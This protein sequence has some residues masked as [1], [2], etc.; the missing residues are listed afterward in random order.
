MESP[1]PSRTT[2]A[3]QDFADLVDLLATRAAERGDQNAY[4]FLGDGTTETARLTYAELEHRA[5]ALAATLQGHGLAG[6]RALL[7]YPPGL[8]FITAFWG[9]VYAGVVA[10]PAYPP[11]A[12]DR[13]GR[14]RAL[15]ADAR[16]AVVLCSAQVGVR[17]EGWERQVP[18]L[19]TARF[20]VDG[21]AGSGLASA[22]AEPAWVRPRVDPDSLAFLQY[23]SGS[24]GIPRGVMITHRNLLHNETMI[25][26]AFAQSEGSVVVG[27]LP[28]YH[29]MGL[30]GCML[31]PVYAGARCI[32][33]PPLAFLQQPRRWLAAVS[34]YRATTSGGPDFAY[35]L[36]LQ[37]PPE[38]RAG[39]DLSCWQVA[40][41]GAEPVRAETLER[42]AEAFSPCGFRRE[43]FYPCYGL[44]E[45]TLFAT[46]GHTASPPT[47]L[48]LDPAS[49]RR[50]EVVP[51]QNGDSARLVS[52]GFPWLEQRLI[53]ADPATA[54]E[55]PPGRVGEIW[56]SGPSVAAGYWSKEEE[57]EQV[58][59]AT[60][61]NGE[62]AFLRT[63][64]LGFVADGHLFIT[65]RLKD[66]IIIH[67]RNYY[68]QDIELSAERSHPC[69]RSS[70]G[71]A[72]AVE[73]EGAER[74]VVVQEVERRRES[75]ASTAA[76][77]VRQAVVE[78]HEV[79]VHEVVL[80]RAGEVPRTSSGKI[81]RRAC[82]DA[83]LSA[84]LH[85]LAR[86]DPA[87]SGTAGPAPAGLDVD[88]LLASEPR[89]RLA[90]VEAFL[91]RAA[92]QAVPAAAS[93][94]P[95]VERLSA[96][97]LDSLAAVDLQHRVA[98]AT[99]VELALAELLEGPRFS[100][101]ALRMLRVLEQGPVPRAA[102]PFEEGADHP[103]SYGQHAL[104]FL[105][106]LAP[107]SGAYNI[108]VAA[109]AGPGLDAGA[110]RR[111]A[112]ALG[113]RHASLRT[114]FLTVAGEPRQRVRPS[115]DLDFVE[116]QVAGA[117]RE[118]AGRVADAGYRPFDLGSGSLLR[119]R[120]FHRPT[121]GAVLVLSIHHI[122]CD[123]W[124]LS[125]LLQELTSLYRQEIGGEPARLTPAPFSYLDYVHRQL[126]RLTPENIGAL[127]EYWRERFGAAPPGLDLPTDRPRPAVPSPSGGSC[128]AIFPT[129]LGAELGRLARSQDTT[130][131]T[132]L[133]AAFQALLHRH[134]G[135]DEVVVGSPSA[136]RSGPE[137]SRVVGYF[138][139]PLPLRAAFS[140]DPPFVDHL[141]RV[142]QEVLGGLAHQDLPFAVLSG[143]LQP[144]RDSLRRSLFQ[145][146][147]VMQQTPGGVPPALAAFALGEPAAR[148]DLCGVSLAPFSL[149]ERRARFDLTLSAATLDGELVGAFEYCREL[150]DPATVSRLAR[151][152]GILLAEIASGPDRRVSELSLLSPEESHQLLFELAV[153]EEDETPEPPTV[154]DLFREQARR[155]PQATAVVC[156]TAS[157]SYAELA[158]RSA[159]LARRLRR[160]GIGPE[161][162]VVLLAGRSPG[163]LVGILGILEAGAAYL[164]VDPSCPEERLRYLLEDARAS[165]VLAENPSALRLA[166]LGV[167]VLELDAEP[168]SPDE[169][170]DGVAASGENLA[171]VIYTSGSTGRPKGVAVEHRQLTSY[172]R[173]VIARLGLA[174]AASFATVSTHAADLG[175][176]M[177][178]GALATGACLHVLSE[179]RAADAEA[180]AE[181]CRRHAV[182]CLKIV[183]SH[184]AAVTATGPLDW[185]PRQLVLGG[186]ASTW[187]E[188]RQLERGAP[189][190]CVFNHYGPTETTVGALTYAATGQTPRRDAAP[191]PVGRPLPGRE[192][193]ILDDAWRP[194]PA[195]VPGELYLGGG[196]SRGYLGAPAATA[197]SFIPHPFSRWPGA[198]LYRS[199]DIGRF[200]PDG[201]I[202]FL[203]RRDHQIK[204]RGFRVE[205]GEITAVLEEHSQV[206]SALVCAWEAMGER[207]LVAYVV[208]A[209]TTL[210]ETS[211]LA[212]FLSARLPDFMVP[213]AFVI[214]PALPLT[215]NGKVDRNRLPA[216]TEIRSPGRSRPP[217]TPVEKLLSEIWAEVLGVGRCCADDDF[218]A[219]GGHSLLATRLVSRLRRSFGVDLPLRALFEAPTVASLASRIEQARGRGEARQAPPILRVPRAGEIPLSFPQNRLWV[220]EQLEPG[221]ATY[222][223]LY[224]A[225]VAG[226]LRASALAAALREIV[227]RHEALRTTF[228][229]V[230]GE[231]FQEVQEWRG[232]ELP[233]IDLL[234]LP[235]C[236]IESEAE[237]LMAEEGQRPFD[238]SGGP[239]LRCAVVRVRDAEHLLLL[240]LHHIV[241]D[242]WS[243]GVL[244]SEL[245]ALY[246]AAVEE[247]PSSLPEPQL[248][249]A[250]FSIWQREWLRG[251]ELEHL[252]AFWLQRLEGRLAP[253]E[254]PADRPRPA[255]RSGRGGIRTFRL[256]APLSAAV[257]GLARR[258]GATRF[259]V[260]LAAF[261]V[262]LQ[263]YC[264]QDDVRVGSPIASRNREEIE[265]LIGFFS[266]TLVLR[267][268]LSG[269]P[270][271]AD[272]LDQVRETTLAAYD[273]QDLPFEKLVEALGGE[274]GRGR[275]SPLQAVFVLQNAPMPDLEFAGLRLTPLEK[276]NG[277]AKF[278][279]VLTL[280]E[281]GGRLDGSLQFD[282]DLFDPTTAER[283]IEHLT[284]LLTDLAA[285][286][287]RRISTLALLP[288]YARHRLLLEG[289]DAHRPAAPLVVTELFARRAAQIPARP[290]VWSAG[291]GPDGERSELRLDYGALERAGNR[292]ARCLGRRGIGPGHRVGICLA[293]S[294]AMVVA[295]LATLKSGAA[296]VPLD[297]HHPRSRLAVAAADAGLS[298]W[299]SDRE[300]AGSVPSG[301]T[302]V[303]DL[304]TAWTSV[305]RFDDAP[306]PPPE[307][308]SPAYVIYTSG[309]T[310][311]PK[312]VVISHRSLSLYTL[313][314]ADAYLAE[315]GLAVALY[316]SLAF[317]LTVTSVF[318]P[319]VA[320]HGICVYRGDRGP[321]IE[322]V[323]RD[324]QV[325]V[326]KLTPS[327]L[328]LL[329]DQPQGGSRIR[330]LVVGGEALDWSLAAAIHESF[331]GRV[332]IFN[333]YGPTEA[334]VGCM[335]HRFE[336]RGSR[337]A[338]VPIGRPAG[339][340]AVYVLD[341]RLEPVPENV[342]GEI[343]IGGECLAQGYLGQPALTAERFL[344]HPFRPG[345]RVYRSGD[346]ARV[347]ADGSLEFLGRRDEQVKHHGHR[348][349]VEEVRAA[350]AEHR[351]VRDSVVRVVRDHQGGQMLVAY[352]V[353]RRELDAT[354]LRA[355]LAERL[356]EE[357]VP[358]LFV[359]L[360]RLPL[361]LNGKVNTEALPGLAEIRGRL[362]AGRAGGDS[363]DRRSPTTDLLLSIWC[364]VLGTP[365]LGQRDNF[366]DFGGHSLLGAQV[367][368]RVRETFGVDLG[369]R[370]LFEQPTVAEMAALIDREMRAGR[371]TTAPP[372]AAVPRDEALP[373]SFAQQ[374]LW[375]MERLRP[376]LATY[377][378]AGG[379]RL[380]G[381]LAVNA[382]A[383]SLDW[384]VGRHESLRTRFPETGTGPA[385]MI[386]P[387]LPVSLPW[388]DLSALPDPWRRA[389]EQRLAR[390]EARRPLD[391]AR[392]PL[393]RCSL[394][395]LAPEEH[396]LLLAV[397]HMICD[398]ASLDRVFDEL[399][400]CYRA[401]RRQEAVPLPPL[402]YH[403]ADFAVWQRRYLTPAVIEPQLAYW[404]RQLAGSP[405]RLVL[406]TDLSP[407]AVPSGRGATHGFIL[408][409]GLL[410]QL[411]ALGRRH[412][413]TLFMTLLAA[414]QTLLHRYSGE[415]RIRVGSP[416]A[417]R[418]P[419]ETAE[420]IG[421][422]LNPAVLCTDLGGN[423]TFAEL[424]HRVREVTLGAHAHQDLPFEVLVEELAPSREPGGSALFHVWFVCQRNPF[425]AID[426]PGLKA[427]PLI[428]DS[429]LAQFDLIL[430][431]L[432]GDEEL[433]AT[434]TYSFDLFRPE[435]VAEM[436]QHLV[437]LLLAVA[438]DEHRKVLQIPL[439]GPD[440]APS[441]APAG[442]PPRSHEEAE[443]RFAF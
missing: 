225:K 112:A 347:W 181:Y 238:L 83:Y 400:L 306:L 320:G 335:I 426:L 420:M 245:A 60:L 134:C 280:T 346:F 192:A 102:A 41:C 436:S 345:E 323:F 232:P 300:W 431:V 117:D 185:L 236:R 35:A 204:I 326:V 292:L 17:A 79:G 253:L 177:I 316:S 359:H 178:F 139:N 72:F 425:S 386:A 294:P 389:E 143:A 255:R 91:R 327:H 413:V 276:H 274:A 355:F 5:R 233:V 170:A 126:E 408:P 48:D 283:L 30:I 111:A 265:G 234:G 92:A 235:G 271:F 442:P 441:L 237:R 354:D 164:P 55:C 273:H 296:Y 324:R 99:G 95:P 50:D 59:R 410:P 287:A 358:N 34:R 205:P 201:S 23:T 387:G 435:I 94:V 115:A 422:L 395:R 366:F 85:V 166:G 246:T 57:S 211:D 380:E 138:V 146:L 284:L 434:F 221:R 339:P 392:G 21:D 101:L 438:G 243:R 259:M 256:P 219:F 58:F 342:V 74:L 379:L 9:C 97:G 213:A 76:V 195:G 1:W 20:L 242:A 174:Q 407:P 45:A 22:D 336:P 262:L 189:G 269:D 321:V 133:L 393:L 129:G 194:I 403:Y 414:Y 279:L 137:W 12:R 14:L 69:L 423:P 161:E 202:E 248:Q 113:A 241:S 75:E 332:E 167:P 275:T 145:V 184:L 182:E 312:G 373:L 261:E 338:T 4:T 374:R 53:I 165:L 122:A 239:L 39:L 268:D 333:E 325:D 361:T 367:I 71:A 378:L 190:L 398:G 49:L 208:P 311:R 33:M 183:P 36:C 372:L 344:P 421:L 343:Y 285:D 108:V 159:Q 341:L 140:D 264:G 44:A 337:P 286:P 56:L 288:P 443:D 244:A 119:W 402:L 411:R 25:R 249:Y 193:Y 27:W 103:L 199:G 90:A 7:L 179:E 176:T 353:S 385:Q 93:A 252:L 229:S 266:N 334:T 433:Q 13:W 130:L 224:F 277:T 158:Q 82:R 218:F 62:G 350:L 302:P 8:D 147:F 89:E 64:D 38:Q 308:E 2:G 173:A 247:R 77:A 116:E 397:H 187:S 31:Q 382:L 212:G 198:R 42:F 331:E 348:L 37:L 295:V 216:P 153:A 135:Q 136:G 278:D 228:R 217:R 104:W 131:Y 282:R 215:P 70:G 19:A 289:T 105:E 214:L 6:E 356:V 293:H 209:R 404:R 362:L 267:A 29:D 377:N 371:Q 424:L 328:A 87:A 313:W 394:L 98:L 118:V 152:F 203:G 141:A 439:G 412:G 168:A 364:D 322:E 307:P 160:Q 340:A 399:T 84:T 314:A 175:H 304:E 61:A 231:P 128:R 370:A 406:P 191:L 349:E 329:A 260:L 11:R 409:A 220:L 88:A 303:L 155:V 369:L 223:L 272:L 51:A 309:S 200:L 381:T 357:T 150:F 68:P 180:L 157:L 384:L 263:R 360:R 240:A 196:V 417:T 15:A 114:S 301:E 365:R 432:E 46:G 250:D 376:G 391:L 258:E 96:L 415:D 318:P 226:P 73:V 427:T 127:T 363:T 80:V 171:Y 305:E 172:V 148:L 319:L 124:S 156:E 151:R 206:A 186:E 28:L 110:L 125:L 132:L 251:E 270:R 222:N 290:A 388:V 32:L 144:E 26:R 298:L 81:R 18:E 368:A 16:P 47:I 106:S 149:A 120:L 43:A 65:G 428:V 163:M 351:E 210:P 24:T 281:T 297:P 207:R 169:G 54:R 188:V 330:R 315:P 86:C 63:G 405:A 197:E 291:P 3:T 317:D 100:D 254:L 396:L 429:G 107:E 40:F 230:R 66:L 162:V 257:A 430:S 142:R 154:Q 401:C 375:F 227:R 52:C 437:D 352:Y 310:G 416:I 299:L 78:E 419:P 383:A 123:F 109:E 390:E 121:R 418:Q 67:G 10:V 440:E